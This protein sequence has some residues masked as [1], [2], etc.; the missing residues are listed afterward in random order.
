VC[1]LKSHV[2]SPIAVRCC[3]LLQDQIHLVLKLFNTNIFKLRNP[4]SLTM[5]LRTSQPLTQIS[6]GN[7]ADGKGRPALR[8]TTISPSVNR[9]FRKCA[10]FKVSKSY[11][12]PMPLIGITLLIYMLYPSSSQPPHHIEASPA[13]Y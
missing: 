6:T 4:T 1:S 10:T 5:A 11:V 9:L 2:C 7:L 12:A 3:C 8:L 13:T